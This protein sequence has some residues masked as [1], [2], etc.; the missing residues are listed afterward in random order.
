MCA[1][2][3][4]AFCSFNCSPFQPPAWFDGWMASAS[5]IATPEGYST[6]VVTHTPA[7][8]PLSSCRTTALPSAGGTFVFCTDLAGV[9]FHTSPYRMSTLHTTTSTSPWSLHHS[10]TGGSFMVTACPIDI[11]YDRYAHEDIP[12]RN[13][14]FNRR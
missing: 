3:H 13:G 2:F 4:Y 5:P 8:L 6:T 1:Y 10:S 9:A 11:Y 14:S 7:W 12:T